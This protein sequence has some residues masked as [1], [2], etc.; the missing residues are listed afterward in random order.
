MK[1]KWAVMLLGGC[2]ATAAFAANPSDQIIKPWTKPLPATGALSV[3]SIPPL[4]TA[5]A[6]PKNAKSAAASKSR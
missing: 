1:S 6:A 5:K 2:L 4:L 3:E